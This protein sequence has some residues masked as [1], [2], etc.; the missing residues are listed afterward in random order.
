M[1]IFQPNFM[2]LYLYIPLIK[3]EIATE[4]NNIIMVYKFYI[5]SNH[6]IVFFLL[7]LS[8]YN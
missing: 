5:L 6:E 8:T 2:E 1:S 4:S 3:I 7:L